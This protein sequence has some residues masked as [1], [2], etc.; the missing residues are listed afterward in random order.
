MIWSRFDLMVKIKDFLVKYKNN[1]YVK[2]KSYE[3]GIFEF[4]LKFFKIPPV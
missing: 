4:E 1:L 2:N 3:T